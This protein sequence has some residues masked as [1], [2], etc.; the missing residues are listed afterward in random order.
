MNISKILVNKEQIMILLNK[1]L[2]K[3]LKLKFKN[4]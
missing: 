4:N 3:Q 2:K 1:N